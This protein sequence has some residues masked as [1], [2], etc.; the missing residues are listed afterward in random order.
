MGTENKE[1]VIKVI[2]PQCSIF[3]LQK[4]QIKFIIYNI[5]T[6]LLILKRWGEKKNAHVSV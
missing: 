1:W 5:Y 6:Y 2:I 3:K 4:M